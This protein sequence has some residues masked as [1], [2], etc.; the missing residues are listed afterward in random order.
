MVIH[1][2]AK[3][4]YAY[5]KE[6]RQTQIQGHT[7]FMNVCDTLYHGDTLTCQTKYDFVKGQKS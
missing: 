2:L 1:P 7:E 6:Q 5:V 3:I 4:L